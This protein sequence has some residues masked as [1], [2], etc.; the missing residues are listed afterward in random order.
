MRKILA[1]LLMLFSTPAF[2][3]GI[4]GPGTG[5]GGGASPT[6]PRFPTGA[7]SNAMHYSNAVCDGT[8]DTAATINAELAALGNGTLVLPNGTCVHSVPIVPNAGSVQILQCSGATKLSPSATMVA[9]IAAT[10]G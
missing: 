10:A 2:A 1:I 9:E 5:G 7:A 6:D 8:T 4:N 3:Q